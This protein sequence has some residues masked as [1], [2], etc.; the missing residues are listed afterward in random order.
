MTST[1]GRRAYS[2]TEFS[3]A[4]SVSRS[5]VFDLIK[6]GD[7]KARKIG[8]KNVILADEAEAWLYSL[9]PSAPGSERA[10]AAARAREAR[11]GNREPAGA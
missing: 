3:R 8:S 11:W 4:Y 6:S 7:L 10:A 5:R 9:P 1:P 2:I